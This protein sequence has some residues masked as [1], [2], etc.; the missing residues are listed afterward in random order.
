[1]RRFDTEVSARRAGAF[2]MET[3]L[4]SSIAL[5]S[6]GIDGGEPVGGNLDLELLFQ[7]AVSNPGALGSACGGTL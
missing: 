5:V 2:A 7:A 6:R 3:R 1:M 4:G